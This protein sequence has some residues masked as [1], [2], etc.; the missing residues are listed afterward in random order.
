QSSVGVPTC[1]GLALTP[2]WTAASALWFVGDVTP[3]ANLLPTVTGTA[4]LASLARSRG[5][6]VVL[7]DT[8]GLVDGPIGR[9][10]KYHK[11]LACG[12]DQV[13]AL[14]RDTELEPLLSLLEG[15]CRELHR[16]TSPP[17]ARDRTFTERRLYR[18]E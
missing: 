4:R 2:P 10:L 12:A 11:A 15:P 5:A 13:I 17:E 16:L 8:T 6:D 1:L 3:I 9:V 7:V 14:Q 18:E